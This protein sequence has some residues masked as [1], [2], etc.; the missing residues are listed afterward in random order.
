M[1]FALG[2][3]RVNLFD[4]DAS[5]PESTRTSTRRFDRADHSHRRLQFRIRRSRDG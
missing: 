1:G 4:R 3:S 5:P 2:A